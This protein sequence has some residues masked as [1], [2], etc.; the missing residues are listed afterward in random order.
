M[1]DERAPGSESVAPAVGVHP[2]PTSEPHPARPQSNLRLRLITAAILIP[3][4]L[5]AIF[6]GG[7]IYVVIV[8]GI[9]ALGTNEFYNFLGAKGARPSRVIG[10]AAAAALPLVVYVGDPFYATSLMTAVLLG[11][12]ILQLARTQIVEAIVSISAT[13]F[14]VVYVGWLLSHAVSVRFIQADL[15]Q[16]YGDVAAIAVHPDAGIFFMLLCLI[17]ALGCDVG[18]YFVGRAYGQRKLAPSISPNKTLEGA[19]G[20]VLTGAAL[21]ILV[22]LVF[23]HLI[24][25]ELSI[26]FGFTATLL[27]ALAIASVG[28]LGDLVESVLK[29]DADLK[30]AGKL[31]PGVGGVLDR[32][33][34]ALFAIPVTYYL[35]L[36][37][38]YMRIG[39]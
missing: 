1:G 16:R 3:P 38:Y 21:S 15:V 17:A 22:K 5:W 4:V 32:I 11:V 23:D 24:P 20:G 19:F 12:M 28:I 26:N 13:F 36:A 39:L 37:Y 18:A 10:T 14:G 7:L 9:A 30:D 29:R 35:L 31:L 6:T 33:D 8:M 34:S 2:V 25:G 27:F